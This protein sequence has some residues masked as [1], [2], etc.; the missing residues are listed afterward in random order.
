MMTQVNFDSSGGGASTS[1][2][3]FN[4]NASTTPYRVECGFAPKTVILV[5]TDNTR[6]YWLADMQTHTLTQIYGGTSY[7]YSSLFNSDFGDI[8]STG[9][10]ILSPLAE[11]YRCIAVTID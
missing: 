3:D 2:A 9:F 1:Y 10:S 5:R 11:T 4:V 6:G 7:D 8:D